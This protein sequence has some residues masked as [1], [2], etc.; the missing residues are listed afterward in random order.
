MVCA[1]ALAEQPTEDDIGRAIIAAKQAA[2]K[3]FKVSEEHVQ[4]AGEPQVL[5]DHVSLHIKTQTDQTPEGSER[6]T[7]PAI[8]LTLDAGLGDKVCGLPRVLVTDGKAELL[9]RDFGD[10]GTNVAAISNQECQEIH[11]G[12]DVFMETVV[13]YKEGPGRF[14]PFVADTVATDVLHDETEK[15]LPHEDRRRLV[16][17]FLDMWSLMLM[18]GIEDVE[19]PDTEVKQDL[20]PSAPFRAT[21]GEFLRNNETA[22]HALLK[23][24]A[25]EN[26]H[27]EAVLPRVKYSRTLIDKHADGKEGAG[28]VPPVSYHFAWDVLDF[29]FIME[30]GRLKLFAIYCRA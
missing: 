21:E 17:L 29:I 8:L 2:A 6:P 3:E 19:I 22:R 18:E 20:N 16:G 30:S 12:V 23:L 25:L 7:T 28:S 15:N 1:T 11:A 26:D 13:N 4:V 9:T 27:V 10:S 24:G 5:P 14:E